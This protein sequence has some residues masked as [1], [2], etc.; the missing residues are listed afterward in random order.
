MARCA[1]CGRPN[2]PDARFCQ[3]CAA[4]LGDPAPETESRRLITAIFVDLVGSTTL[5]E[6]ADPE[7][8][9]SVQTRYFDAVERR[10]TAAGGT[11]EKFIGD[12]VVG[13]FGVP[14]A[15]EDDA[16]RAVRAA[17]S[18]LTAIADLNAEVSPALPELEVRIG[19]NTGEAAIGPRTWGQAF[20]AG[21]V[22]NTAARLQQ[23]AQPGQ[24]LIGPGVGLHRWTTR[25][26][27]L[28]VL[29]SVST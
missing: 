27:T 1:H 3:N 29:R 17:E 7:L 21:D 13:V 18:I 2:D 26:T 6:S 9:R 8:V 16:L 20:V 4:A 24:I 22:V 14:N 11:V 5:G 25:S 10:L 19:I 15:H 12:A 23:S 28:P